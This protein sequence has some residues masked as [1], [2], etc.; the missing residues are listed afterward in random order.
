MR[1]LGY[2]ATVG[3]TFGEQLDLSKNRPAG[4]DYLRMFLALLIIFWHTIIICYG[5]G[6]ETPFWSGWPRPLVF[7]I[8][9]S[10]F[11]LSG[12]LVAGSLLRNSIQAF[13]TLRAI[14]IYP[15]LFCEVIISALIIGP[16]LSPFSYPEYVG[17]D[18]F[19]TYLLN[20]VGYIHYELP[21][22]FLHNPAGRFVNLQLWTIPYELECYVTITVLA[23]IGVARRPIFLLFGVCVIRDL[24]GARPNRP[25]DQFSSARTAASALVPLRLLLYLWRNKIPGGI[26]LF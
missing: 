23:I 12:F 4:F 17:S 15:A 18:L 21:R 11:A 6:A 10:F 9:P 8:V 3:I 14:R 26:L 5:I 25:A 22:L 13:L 20:C 19:F 16:A 2:R 24:Y 1:H 7:F